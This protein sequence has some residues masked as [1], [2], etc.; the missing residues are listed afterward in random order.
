M[1]PSDQS[2]IGRGGRRP[3]GV[4]VEFGGLDAER[5]ADAV[6]RRFGGTI[7]RSGAHRLY[8]DDTE[9]GRFKVELD[10]DWVHAADDDTGFMNKAKQLLGDIG[11]EVVPTEVVTP[12]MPA[13]RLPELDSLVAD[14]ARLGAEGTRSGL[15]YGFG[16][17]LNPA[18]GP[19]DLDAGPI[20]R[21]LQAYMLAAPA[22]RAAID[23]PPMRALLPFVEPFPPG[24]VEL[25]L[26]PD[27]DPPLPQLIDDYLRLNP[28]RNRELDLLPLFAELDGERVRRMVP[29]PHVSARPTFH[30]RLPNAD[31]ESPD[32]TVAGQW[33][34]WLQV[35]RAA[36][37]ADELAERLAERQRTN[38]RRESLWASLF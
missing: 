3:V 24:Y 5:A 12:P 28:T 23:V 25:V 31:F 29:D 22:L 1:S 17:H 33:A 35:E 11:R 32:W 13:G 18:L 16:L 7:R 34:R 9:L 38:A 10:W 19:A 26:A 20:R 8:V 6:R 4:E 36:L 37:D 14:L 30:W 2:L 27:Y 21:V 15:L